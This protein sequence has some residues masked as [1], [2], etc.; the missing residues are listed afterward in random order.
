[1][2]LNRQQRR[3]LAWLAAET[4]RTDPDLAREL[5][6]RPAPNKRVVIPAH[7]LAFARSITLQLGVAAT[8][9][10]ASAADRLSIALAALAV[11]PATLLPLVRHSRTNAQPTRRDLDW[12]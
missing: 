6:V 2:R 11:Y 9:L 3:T 1:M 7:A 5:A 4:A 8:C 12:S 10:A